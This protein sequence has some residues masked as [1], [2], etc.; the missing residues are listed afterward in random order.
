MD[1][2]IAHNYTAWTY[3]DDDNILNCLNTAK[4]TRYCLICGDKDIQEYSLGH[5]DGEYKFLNSGDSCA[6]GGTVQLFCAVCDK[7]H[8]EVDQHDASCKL[9]MS[10]V[11]YLDKGKHLYFEDD[12]YET[13]PGDADNCGSKRYTCRICGEKIRLATAHAFIVTSI[14]NKAPTCTEA[15]WTAKKYCK[16]CAFVSEST[17]IPA[18]GHFFSWGEGGSKICDVCG[19]YETDIEDGMGELAVCDH[20]CH[21]KG[22][23]A[24][25]LMKVLSFFWKF[26]GRNH[27]CACGAIH[28]HDGVDEE[29]ND[30]IT[31]HEKKYDKTGKLTSIEY[32]CTECKVKNKKHTF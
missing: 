19:A 21:N 2:K 27:F 24:K 32:S 5:T 20:F 25:V 31:I 9:H 17:V 7:G 29:G 23:I 13:L 12:A 10:E 16:N 30:I 6:T 15:G 26:L 4:K 11:F 1:T 28:Y 8:T 22:T 3:T 18:T 14:T